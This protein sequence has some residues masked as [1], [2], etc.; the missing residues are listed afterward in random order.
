MYLILALIAVIAMVGLGFAIANWR[1]HSRNVAIQALLDDA[2][3]LEACLL[4]TRTRMRQ[5]EGMLGRLPAD[6]TESARAS[7]ASEAGIQDAMKRVLSHRL[8][9]RENAMSATVAKLREVGET[10]RKS[11]VQ[12]QQQLAR[13]DGAGVELQAAYAQSDALM[14]A[15]QAQE[16]KADGLAK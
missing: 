12:L 11:L 8:W 2:D 5:L 4:E 15:T 1:Q 14:G 7:L 3:R 6:I 9:I 10:A 16:P 13:L